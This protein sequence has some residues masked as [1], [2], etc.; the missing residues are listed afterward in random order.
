MTEIHVGAG[1]WNMRSTARRPAA[2]PGLYRSAVEDA[3]EAEEAGFDSFWL[4]EHRFWYDGW[5][6]QPLLVAS[7][8]AEATQRIHVG[9]AMYLLP[10]H[11]PEVAV[12]AVESMTALFGDRLELGVAIG[13]RH[14]EYD[15]LGLRLA[16]RAPR[17]EGHLDALVGAGSTARVWLGGMAEPAIHRAARR[18]LSLLLPPTLGVTKVARIVERARSVAADYGSALPRIGIMKDVWVGDS[19]ESARRYFLPR[20]SRHYRE[21]VT[22]WWALDDRGA[23]DE[24]KLEKQLVRN[25]STVLVGSAGTVA[26]ALAEFVA[27]GVDSFVLQFH[28]EET[29]A[30]TRD[31]IQ[32]AGSALV[33]RL[34]ELALCA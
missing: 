19:D 21:Y 32:L 8:V 22:A 33:P 13:Y 24:G 31:Q 15:G 28:L 27:V 11:S 6:P 12:G 29:S 5:C 30:E 2:L 7:A 18:G 1:L 25:L 34:R 26:D 9:T 3:A 16:D 10:Q 17:L 14:D 20:I 4:G 23:V